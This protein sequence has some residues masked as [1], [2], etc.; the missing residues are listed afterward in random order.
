MNFYINMF[1]KLF[2]ITSPLRTYI[3]RV[4]LKNGSFVTVTEKTESLFFARQI[5]IHKFGDRNVFS[6]AEIVSTHVDESSEVLSPQQLQVKSLSDKA[7]S[8]NQ[9][10]KLLKARQK[11]AKAEDNLRKANSPNSV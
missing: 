7:K 5:F 10:A 2:E 8:Y 4:R 11:L 3:A 6:V 1:M 9:Q